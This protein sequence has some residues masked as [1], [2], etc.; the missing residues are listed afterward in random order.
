MGLLLGEEG[1]GLG[2]QAISGRVE[3]W[4][5]AVQLFLRRALRPWR[6]PGFCRPSGM[7]IKG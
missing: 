1:G 7:G 2:I 4:S 3:G 6:G 5:L